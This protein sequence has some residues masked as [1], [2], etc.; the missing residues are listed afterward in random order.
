MGAADARGYAALQSG[1]VCFDR[2]A[3]SRTVFRG[4]HAADTVAG[5]VTSDV[6]ALAPGSGQYAA[7]L[8]PKGKIVADVRIFA[9]TDGLLVDTTPRAAPGWRE[10]LRKYV[11]PR[12]TPYADVSAATGDVGVFGER[13]AQLLGDAVELAGATLEALGPYDHVTVPN[14]GD[15]A[16][17]DLAAFVARVPDLGVPGF[18][19]IGPAAAYE[20]IGRRL[21]VA[22]VV[23]GS[24]DLWTIARLEAG[25][26]E[27]GIDMDE[28]TIPQE[29]NFEELD[30]ISYTKGCYTGQETVA[31]IH[32]R[33]HVNRHLRGLQLTEMRLPPP[34]AAVVDETGAAVGDVRSS[35]PS[36]RFGPIA[37]GMIR[38]EVASGARVIIRWSGLE[39]VPAGEIPARV[40]GLPFG[41]PPE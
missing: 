29:A 4:A 22:G 3:R 15:G 11:N 40:V 34:G 23:A 37:L 26:P 17:I 28:T 13:A 35:A 7:A 2:R 10:L 31:R 1:A 6:K 5:L 18:D 27:W 36:P 16:S 30:A 12:I 19:L 25:R 24:T 20:A 21:G 14:A 39:D 38:R 41:Y 8:T 33:G 32:F 9:L